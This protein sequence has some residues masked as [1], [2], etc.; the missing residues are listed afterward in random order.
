[1]GLCSGRC[2]VKG[3]PGALSHAQERY[4]RAIC[5]LYET[6]PRVLQADVARALGRS[7]P[8]VCR[9]V[10]LLRQQGLLEEGR[11]ELVPTAEALALEGRLRRV[12]E[13]LRA[14]LEGVGLPS[15]TG[16]AGLEELARLL[17]G[18]P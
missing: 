5:Q 16:E 1:M 17:G 8:S 6:K 2:A 7:K 15:G 12:R 18:E 9:A 10:A 13:R 11:Q 14:A 3:G 4:L